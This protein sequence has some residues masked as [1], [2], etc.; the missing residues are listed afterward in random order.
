M[1]QNQTE[2]QNDGSTLPKWLESAL[3]HFVVV[4][5]QSDF[6]GSSPAR[7]GADSGSQTPDSPNSDQLITNQYIYPEIRYVFSD[8]DFAPTLDLVDQQDPTEISVVIDFDQSGENVVGYKSF[9]SNWQISSV[10]KASQD[11]TFSDTADNISLLTITG[12]SSEIKLPN[13]ASSEELIAVLQAR[14]AQLR[15]ML[16]QID[17]G[18]NDVDEI[19]S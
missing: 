15:N 4:Q 18:H 2:N 16:A 10:D 12:A 13:H 6:S 8:D 9:T 14:N 7:R 19:S 11:A 5:D 1:D 17:H 3:P